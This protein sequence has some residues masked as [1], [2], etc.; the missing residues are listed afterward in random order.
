MDIDVEDTSIITLKFNNIIALISIDMI[1]KRKNRTCEIIGSDATILLDFIENKNKIKQ[2]SVIKDNK[3][4]FLKNSD[5]N[6]FAGFILPPL[7]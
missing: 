1:N 3:L 4:N 5:A 2:F 6:V 7:S